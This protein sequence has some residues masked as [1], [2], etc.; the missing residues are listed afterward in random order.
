MSYTW[1]IQAAVKWNVPREKGLR[2][3][4]LSEQEL[5]AIGGTME[6]D[7]LRLVARLPG[8][9]RSTGTLLGQEVTIIDVGLDSVD[10][11]S[12]SG[13]R[14]TYWPAF[15]LPLA[16]QDPLDLLLEGL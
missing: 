9:G 8:G 6:E 15:L 16:P 1:D 4:I 3:R 2:C 7:A 13:F 5:R 12:D 11:E 10:V 14:A